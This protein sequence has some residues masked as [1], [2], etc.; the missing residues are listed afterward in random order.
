MDPVEIFR[1]GRLLWRV[2]VGEELNPLLSP[3]ESLVMEEEEEEEEE[4]SPWK[5]L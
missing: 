3:C 2:E 4:E 5:Q 1:E